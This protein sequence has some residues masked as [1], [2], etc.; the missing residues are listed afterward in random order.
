METVHKVLKLIEVREDHRHIKVTS[1]QNPDLVP[2]PPDRRTWNPPTFMSYWFLNKM[3]LS[4]FTSAATLLSYGLSVPYT[5]AA[6]IVANVITLIVTVLNGQP[7]SDHHISFT[8]YSRCFFGTKGFYLAILLRSVTACV[9]YANQSFQG[10]LIINTIIYTWSKRY[11]DWKNTLNPNLPFTAK[12]MIGFI[13]FQIIILP[14]SL[15]RPHK[16]RYSMAISSLAAFFAMIGI[17]AYARKENG[18]YGTLMHKGSSVSGSKFSWMFMQAISH[19]FGGATAGI[20]NKPD[21]TRFGTGRYTPYPGSFVGVMLMGT[22]IPVMGVLT[23]SA[24]QDHYGKA[25]W[26]PP[27]ILSNWLEVYYTP[28]CR[29][30]VF[31]ASLSFLVMTLVYCTL[32]NLWSFGM[33]FSGVLPRFI[34]IRR[35]GLFTLLL[36]WVIQPWKMFNTVSNFATVIV[37]FSVFMC[38]L[39]GLLLCDYFV[40]RRRKLKLTHLYMNGKDSD[41]YEFYGFNVKGIFSFTCGMAPGL[42]GLVHSATPRL[43]V[44]KGI[45]DYY[46]GNAIFGF[47]IAFFLYWALCMIWPVKDAGTMDAYDYYGTYSEADCKYWGVA[48]LSEVPLEELAKYV[49]IPAMEED[50]DANESIVE[51]V[52]SATKSQQYNVEVTKIEGT[53]TD[54]D[55][56]KID[57]KV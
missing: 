27:D 46:Y 43:K 16:M 7:G 20:I 40:I 35:G 11:M 56:N 30:G 18:S 21:W 6:V 15:S 49:D 33:D 31:F 48:P 32:L 9:W 12:D 45:M 55:S 39:I 4:T 53:G 41:Y 22:V 5:M 51:A 34:N 24:L 37:A 8:S 50:K 42:P 47:S 17:T 52:L 36:A 25:M 28:A 14:M 44:N 1:S 57:S 19:W 2:L 3:T 38:P 54:S 23:A 10:G 13:L 26:N 29:A